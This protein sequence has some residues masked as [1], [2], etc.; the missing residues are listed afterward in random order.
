MLLCLDIGNTIITFGLYKGEIL[1]HHWRIATEVHRTADEYAV[2]VD[3]L[4]RLDGG[5]NPG[6][7]GCLYGQRCSTP[8]RGVCGIMPDDTGTSILW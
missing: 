6:Y 5:K 7:A 8:H 3:S 1:A 4:F 2:L